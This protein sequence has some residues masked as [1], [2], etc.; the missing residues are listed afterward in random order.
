MKRLHFKGRKDVGTD[1]ISREEKMQKCLSYF[2]F[3]NLE[4]NT[5]SI[6]DMFDFLNPRHFSYKFATYYL[7]LVVHL[8]I[9]LL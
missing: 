6:N 9:N 8:L 1:Y 2:L 7:I 4:N 5:L 3:R